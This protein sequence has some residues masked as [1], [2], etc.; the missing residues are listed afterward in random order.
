MR[1]VNAGGRRSHLRHVVWL[2][3][4]LALGPAPAGEARALVVG[5]EL[6]PETK[7][8]FSHYIDA[9]EARIAQNVG[10]KDFLYSCPTP[11]QRAQLRAG[12]V[13]IWPGN[14]LKNAKD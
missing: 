6:S 1:A 2:A 4:A 12:E 10:A 13:L 14:A 11:E 8:G 5:A 7:A 9:V 3:G